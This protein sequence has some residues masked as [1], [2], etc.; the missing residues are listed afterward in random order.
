MEYKILFNFY[1]NEFFINHW[2]WCIIWFDFLGNSPPY[3]EMPNEWVT[4]ADE[5][6]TAM[7]D[8][9]KE[10]LTAAVTYM[11]MVGTQEIFINLKF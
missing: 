10:E 11:A 1:T 6:I 3:K 5:C 7:R 8:Q 4:M 2:F 9:V